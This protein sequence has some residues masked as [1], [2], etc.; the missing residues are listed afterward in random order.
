MRSAIRG[1]AM[2]R[3]ALIAESRFGSGPLRLTKYRVPA[4]RKMTTNNCEQATGANAGGPL[5]LPYR[6]AWADHIAQLVR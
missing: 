6:T 3:D 1:R 2:L 5:V 4:S